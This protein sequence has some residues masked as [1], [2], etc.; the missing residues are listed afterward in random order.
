MKKLTTLIQVL[1]WF[2]LD[3][4]LLIYYLK[5]NKYMYEQTWNGFLKDKNGIVRRAYNSEKHIIQYKNKYVAA[6]S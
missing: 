3:L 1:F 5:W 4:L 2:L 6:L